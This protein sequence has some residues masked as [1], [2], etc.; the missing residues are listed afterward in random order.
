MSA[1]EVIL[2]LFNVLFTSTFS[3]SLHT[4]LSLPESRYDTYHD[5]IFALYRLAEG[6]LVVAKSVLSLGGLTLF[7]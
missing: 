3:G 5:G 1:H 2:L 4:T 7:C 6:G